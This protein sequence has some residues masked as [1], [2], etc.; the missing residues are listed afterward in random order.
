MEEDLKKDNLEIDEETGEVLKES[1][2]VFKSKNPIIDYLG[3][4]DSKP[5]IE[6]VGIL[7]TT[8]TNEMET[9]N[10]LDKSLRVRSNILDLESRMKLKII[11]YESKI[12]KEKT[13]IYDNTDIYHEVKTVDERE[14][15]SRGKNQHYNQLKVGLA[16]CYAALNYI[17]KLSK[18]L[19]E[20][21]YVNN[22]RN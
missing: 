3:E 20:S 10:L 18:L 7:Q 1:R 17:E 14:N 19:A 11:E 13:A 21:N 2:P 15:L 6:A 5:L 16:C 22:T 9:N 4:E 8:P 12:A